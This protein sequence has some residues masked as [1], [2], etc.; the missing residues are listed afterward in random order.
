VSN[1]CLF[2]AYTENLQSFLIYKFTKSFFSRHLSGI[3][4]LWYSELQNIGL[5]ILP[6]ASLSHSLSLHVILNSMPIWTVDNAVLLHIVTISK[7]AL[8]RG[9]Y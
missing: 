1:H 8:K 4:E 2:A 7:T 3:P 5:Q 6:V 9:N